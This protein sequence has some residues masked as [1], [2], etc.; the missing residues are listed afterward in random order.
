MGSLQDLKAA[1]RNSE[2]KM[3]KDVKN[4]RASVYDQT[5]NTPLEKP[6]TVEKTN[7]VAS[8]VTAQNKERNVA[9]NSLLQYYIRVAGSFA[10]L[11][12]EVLADNVIA[13]KSGL[14][15]DCRKVSLESMMFVSRSFGPIMAALILNVDNA[16]SVFA[17][18]IGKEMDL[19]KV[20]AED[21]IAFHKQAGGYDFESA[22]QVIE[23]GVTRYENDIE[24][25]IAD[26]ISKSLDSLSD[27]ETSRRVDE[28][29]SSYSQR[30]ADDIGMILS[31]PVYL[32]IAVN[33]NA[34][35]LRFA[36][37]V[38]NKVS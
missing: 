25:G 33:N 32:L 17:K 19:V 11:N 21:R 36:V 16:R 5:K 4:I 9:I 35:F 24:L 37:D 13:V 10:R 7:T 23:L 20:D 12:G 28:A 18:A 14:P 30:D 6:Q 8:N 29:L 27:T 1:M 38:C 2:P 3:Q 15:E 31:N 34:E 26:N 22:S